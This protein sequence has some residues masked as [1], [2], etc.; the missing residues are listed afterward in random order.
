MIHN[1]HWQLFVVLKLL[2]NIHKDLVK[3]AKRN[4]FDMVDSD[5]RG[6]YFWGAPK[7]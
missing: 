1:W 3:N 2:E 5:V 6:Y 7:H 4:T